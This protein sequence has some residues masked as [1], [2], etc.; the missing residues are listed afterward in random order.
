MKFTPAVAAATLATALALPGSALAQ[1]AMATT[2]LNM[3]AG[4]G[5]GYPVVGTIPANGDVTIHGCTESGNWC[6]VTVAGERG[7]SY[8]EYLAFDVAGD[9]V[10]VPNVGDRV[11][12]PVATYEVE[13]YWNEHYRDRPF[14]EER[15]V[16]VE[17][18]RDAGGTLTGLA[19]G[20]ATGAL[21]GGPVGAAIGGAAGAAMGTALEP[22]DRVRTYVVEQDP[23]PV[24]LE[25]EVV[26]GAGVP[27]AAPVYSIP[28]YEYEYAYINGQYVLIEPQ[29]REIV[30]VYR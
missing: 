29:T 30:H 4:P 3:R 10:R 19:G 13:P 20:A 2:D 24:V 5:P 23:E 21:I 12:V 6:D 18:S 7:W 26:V 9:P 27:E 1:A 17:R 8:A 22:P 11:E 16:Y 25:G 15:E 14:Y 28:E